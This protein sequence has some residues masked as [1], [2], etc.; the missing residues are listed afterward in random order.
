MP[1]YY[2]YTKLVTLREA[3]GSVAEI[4][5]QLKLELGSV[6][7]PI[8]LHAPVP[9]LL[10][11]AWSILRETLLAGQAPRS[12]KEAVAAT[13]SKRNQCPW[14]VDIHSMMLAASGHSDASAAIAAR[15]TETITDPLLRAV[16][17]WAEQPLLGPPPGDPTLAAEL[18]GT[19]VAF[20]YLN[21]MVNV[22]LVESF[23]PRTRFVRNTL[24]AM[25][26]MVL[27]PLAHRKIMPGESLRWL[28]D[29]ALPMDLSWASEIPS[30][31]RSFA[32]FAVA[33]EEQ[34]HAAVPEP[35]RMILRDQL[36]RW[37]GTAPGLSRAWVDEAVK[38]LAEPHAVATRLVLLAAMASYQIDDTVV[39]AFQRHYPSEAMLV[40]AL[41]WASFTAAR[42]INLVRSA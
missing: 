24:T 36:A 27:R 17:L 34:G 13:V 25:L 16:V 3:H 23:L 9:A 35:A 11:G 8:A 28:S 31:A 18:I 32:G 19:A 29:A 7:D 40:S 20:H 30:I 38:G 33:V 42:H 5:T 22:L 12:L 26:P 14:C 6:A 1:N 39:A 15:H 2:R 10:A 41:A 4:Y 21:R 37:D